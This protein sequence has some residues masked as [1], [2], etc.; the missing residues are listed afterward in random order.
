MHAA[1]KIAVNAALIGGVVL[2]AALNGPANGNFTVI[3]PKW[4]G[5]PGAFTAIANA[6][7]AVIAEGSLDAIASGFSEDPQFIAR[8]HREGALLVFNMPGI[9][10]CTRKK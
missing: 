9:P 3:S 5:F 8:L 10:G 6:G 4:L 7:G 2:A 1:G